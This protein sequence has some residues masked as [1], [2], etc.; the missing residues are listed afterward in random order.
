M[1]EQE[2]R[3][4]RVFISYARADSSE[5]AEEIR[6]GLTLAGF[7]AYLDKHDIEKSED[8]SAGAIIPQ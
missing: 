1:A 8:V 6:S 2:Q 4:S 7:E 3:K 5:I